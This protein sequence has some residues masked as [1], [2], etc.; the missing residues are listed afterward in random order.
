MCGEPPAFILGV[1]M[2]IL[3]FY[4]LV[5][6]F[7]IRSRATFPCGNVPGVPAQHPSSG[8]LI[9]FN[10]EEMSFFAQRKST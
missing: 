9:P 6:I 1:T 4:L 10:N 7:I 3:A 2:Y 8:E 5:Y